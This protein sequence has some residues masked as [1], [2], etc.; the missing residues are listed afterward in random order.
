MDMQ[1]LQTYLIT[2]I[3]DLGIKDPC[4]DRVL[5]RRS[6]ADRA[7]HRADPGRHEPHRPGDRGPPVHQ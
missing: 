4:R 5:D 2:T 6:L 7:G 1:S 3:T